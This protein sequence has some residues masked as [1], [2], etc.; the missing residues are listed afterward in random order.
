MSGLHWTLR[1]NSADCRINPEASE[2][3]ALCQHLHW[4]I[5]ERSTWGGRHP[6]RRAPRRPILP[7][8]K[9]PTK[10]SCCVEVKAIPSLQRGTYTPLRVLR[11]WPYEESKMT[12][13]LRNCPMMADVGTA[14]A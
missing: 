3:N 11:G 14:V 5:S 4:P 2:D 9:L 1:N 13:N 6:F 8:C 12:M 10:R 7:T